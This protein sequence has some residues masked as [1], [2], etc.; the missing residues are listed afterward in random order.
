M[1]IGLYS[2]AENTPDLLNGNHLQSPA[3]RLRDLLEEIELADQ[4]GLDFYG[5]G[6]HHRPDF[7]ASSP[8][9]ILAA[10]AART[11][12]IRLSTAVTVLSSDDPIRVWQQFSTLDLL[13]NGRAE[14]MAG[15]GSFVESFPLFGYDLN[16]YDELFEEKLQ[17]LLA[18]RKGGKVDW[19][20]SA[21]TRPI[22]GMELFPKPV[23]DPL[24]LWIA[25]GGTPNSV[26]RAAYFGLPLMIAIIGGRPQQFQPLVRL[27]RD[28]AAKMNHDVAG[29]PVGISS[30]GFI[31]DT[32]QEAMDIAFPAH[33]AAMSRI[34]KE[35]GWPPTTREQFEA[36]A[37][38]Q[39]AYFMG[40]P[41]Q[42][43]D[44]ILMQHEWFGHDRFGLQLSVGTLPHAKVMHAIE[45]LGT[46]VKPAIDK[47]LPRKAG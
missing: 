37:G 35:R 3:E 22:P 38:P 31:A 12:T 34:G 18:I 8:V 45:L 9:T 20:G 2:F 24:P 40:S 21:H 26:A 19:P 30:H 27:Y 44:K 32:S 41:Q 46:V 29:L 1:Q 23:Q 13:S 7:V 14:I 28:T 10:A 33:Q 5:L 16:D 15:R 11:S 36:G 47:A 39:G 6:E 42:V 17:E 25:V 43:I 4:L